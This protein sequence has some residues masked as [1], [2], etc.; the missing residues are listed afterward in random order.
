MDNGLVEIL[1]SIFTLGAGAF[2][3][4]TFSKKLEKIDEIDKRLLKLEI[5]EELRKE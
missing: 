2:L 5:K 1:R 3:W 4:Q